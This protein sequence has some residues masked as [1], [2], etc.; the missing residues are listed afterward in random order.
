MPINYTKPEEIIPKQTVQVYKRELTIEWIDT[1]EK[2]NGVSFT[3]ERSDGKKF[4]FKADG[5]QLD[6]QLDVLNGATLREFFD[7]IG[8]SLLSLNHATYPSAEE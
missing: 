7:S 3:V 6:Q 2:N 8:N 5:D 4:T 1:N